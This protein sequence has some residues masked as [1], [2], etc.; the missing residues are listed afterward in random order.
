MKKQ[1]VTVKTYA[2]NKNISVQHV[3]RLCKAGK[4]KHEI[5]DGVWFIAYTQN[6]IQTINPETDGN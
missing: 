4:L 5:I 6:K 2:R 3:Y 1:L